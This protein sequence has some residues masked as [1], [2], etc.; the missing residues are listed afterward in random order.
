MN[1]NPF[2]RFVRRVVG[3]IFCAIFFAVAG[4]ITGLV[5]PWISNN[6]NYDGE[7]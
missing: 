1:C 5:F 7:L 3:S 4:F 6:P 2:F